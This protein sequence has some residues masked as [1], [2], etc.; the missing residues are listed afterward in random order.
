[1]ATAKTKEKTRWPQTDTC[2]THCKFHTTC[3]EEHSLL[4]TQERVHCNGYYAN[5]KAEVSGYN[6][7]EERPKHA[8]CIINNKNGSKT[9]TWL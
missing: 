8:M 6:G 7:N 9:K 5:G 2:C 4:P 3:D 1:M